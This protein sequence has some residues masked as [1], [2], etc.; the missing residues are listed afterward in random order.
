MLFFD[1]KGLWTL[2]IFVVLQMLG[3]LILAGSP[4]HL[5]AGMRIA[6]ITG[7]ALGVLPPLIRPLLIALVIPAVMVDE[8]QRGAQDRLVGTILVRR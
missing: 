3:G 4:G 6:T 8:D 7:G 2:A 5:V 1:Y